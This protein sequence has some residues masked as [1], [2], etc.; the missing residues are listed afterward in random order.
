MP[1]PA[2]PD[3]APRA[4]GNSHT[5]AQVY[6]GVEAQRPPRRV[7]GV[8]A[9]AGVEPGERRERQDSPRGSPAAG[10]PAGPA[11][12]ARPPRP[13]PGQREAPLRYSIPRYRT[14]ARTRNKRRRLDDAGDGDGTV[15]AG[16]TRHS[17]HPG[18]V[19]TNRWMN[20]ALRRHL[21]FT[22]TH[23]STNAGRPTSSSISTR[24]WVP[25]S[26]SATPPLPMSIAFCDG[27]ST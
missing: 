12:T 19:Q 8:A 14:R 17:S 21:G 11:P 23:S 3:A 10:A 27:L 18:A 9:R 6:R 24:A 16:Q 7:V 25:T 4:V 1:R 5:E 26:L 22:F 2:P 13:W 15:T 20:P